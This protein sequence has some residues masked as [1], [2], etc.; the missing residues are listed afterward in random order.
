MSG[1]VDWKQKYMELRS[2]Y[3]NAIDV[4]F[5][6]GFQEGTKSAEME[7]LQA[8]QAQAEEEAAMAAQQG[9]MPGEELPPEELPPGEEVMAE[10]E[11]GDE[12]GAS[13]DE[14]ESYVKSEGKDIDITALMK[15]LHK[16]Q[17]KPETATPKSAKAKK[18]ESMIK[19]WDEEESASQDDS[20]D[21]VLGQS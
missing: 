8:Q 2:K 16:Q 19:G 15:N 17:K 13:I 21:T 11:G 3:M 6:L 18:I 5:K 1:K 14:L 7:N 20:D 12:L 4:S 9:M 10:E